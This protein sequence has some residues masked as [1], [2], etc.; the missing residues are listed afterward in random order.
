MWAK[1]PIATPETI[2]TFG[3]FIGLI[4]EMAYTDAK[5]DT[6]SANLVRAFR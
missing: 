4:L 2:S 6:T 3:R 1:D 5:P